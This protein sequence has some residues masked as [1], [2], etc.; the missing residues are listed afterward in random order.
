M[1]ETAFSPP[2]HDWKILETLIAFSLILLK[3]QIRPRR[4]RRWKGGERREEP[5]L[6]RGELIERLGMFVQ[7]SCFDG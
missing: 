3:H 6:D 7:L 5:T 2:P 4:S 1:T